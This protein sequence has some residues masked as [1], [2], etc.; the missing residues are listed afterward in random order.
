MVLSED[1]APTFW[2]LKGSFEGVLGSFGGGGI[3]GFWACFGEFAAWIL[4]HNGSIQETG[5]ILQVLGLNMNFGH[6]KFIWEVVEN[7]RKEH[8]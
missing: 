2:V 3:K 8:A 5:P 4:T 1:F 6:L 7:C